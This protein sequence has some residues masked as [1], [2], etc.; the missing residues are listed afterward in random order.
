MGV[1]YSIIP[2]GKGTYSLVFQFC[3]D[4]NYLANG[5]IISDIGTFYV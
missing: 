3:L 4:H 1:D 5:G 2:G